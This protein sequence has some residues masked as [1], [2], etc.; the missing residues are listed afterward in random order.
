MTHVKKTLYAENISWA[1]LHACSQ[2]HD[3]PMDEAKAFTAHGQA[4]QIM[5]TQ[6]GHVAKTWHA[7]L[8]SPQ[9]MAALV[10]MQLKPRQLSRACC[11]GKI[12][13]QLTNIHYVGKFFLKYKHIPSFY[14]LEELEEIRQLLAPHFVSVSTVI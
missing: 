12:K 1:C 6:C 7:S 11:Q 4:T 9:T 3:S 13:S 2:G 5:A 14:R 10:D 8:H